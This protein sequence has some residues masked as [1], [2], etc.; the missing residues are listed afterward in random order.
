VFFLAE[1]PIRCAAEMSHYDVKFRFS[2]DKI[3]VSSVNIH[4]RPFFKIK[5]ISTDSLTP[6]VICHSCRCTASMA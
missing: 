6:A 4:E 3:Q 2:S 1:E 5:N